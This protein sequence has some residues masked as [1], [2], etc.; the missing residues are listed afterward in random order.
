MSYLVDA[1]K[2]AERERFTRQAQ[3]ANALSVDSMPVASGSRANGPLIWLVALLVASNVALAIYVWR[4]RPAT[5]APAVPMA[6]AQS[7]TQVDTSS[8]PDFSVADRSASETANGAAPASGP[9]KSSP[10]QTPA[11]SAATAP[12]AVAE[13]KN[14]Q[15]ADA[16]SANGASSNGHVTYSKTPLTGA[17]SQEAAAGRV[18]HTSGESQGSGDANVPDQAD[19]SDVPSV[20]INGQLY[21]TLPGRSFILVNG[22][23]YHEGERL[24]AGPA[25]ESIGPNGAT[26]RYHGQRYH[27]PGPG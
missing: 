16:S 6:A 4:P 15:V 18:A 11:V 12:P 10:A 14:A 5:S 13:R 19:M 22:R 20:E 21:S 9:T 17:G 27:V 2:K 23:R 7:L 3:S 1:L 26:L 8:T 25:V 24:A